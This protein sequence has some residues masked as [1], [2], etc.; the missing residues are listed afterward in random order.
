MKIT[1]HH[2]IPHNNKPN[3]KIKSKKPLPISQDTLFKPG[4]P[5][6]KNRNYSI[7]TEAELSN[8]FRTLG[9]GIL[10]GISEV[11]RKQ[12]IFEKAK[13]AALA[14]PNF[15]QTIKTWGFNPQLPLDKT[16]LFK[17]A[18]IH[19]KEHGS[20][21]Q[22]S[23]QIQEYG[24]DPKNP[25]DKQYLENFLKEAA[26]YDGRGTFELIDNWGLGRDKELFFEAAI[27]AAANSPDGVLKRIMD[28]HLFDP[29]IPEDKKR[30]HQLALE[31][32]K[33]RDGEFSCY[34]PDF[35][36][37]FS[38]P[39]E[40]EYLDKLL[41]IS[42]KHDGWGTCTYIDHY[43]LDPEK[44]K[45]LLFEVAMTAATHDPA[46]V[47][48]A[49]VDGFPFDPSDAEDK[50]RL[51]Q[52]ALQLSLTTSGAGQ[53]SRYIQHYG[54]DA[55]NPEDNRLLKT[56]A[57]QTWKD[58]GLSEFVEN[59]DN[60][61]FNW[62]QEKELLSD[63]IKHAAKY[64][65]TWH[66]PIMFNEI[67]NHCLD[68]DA[69][70]FTKQQKALFSTLFLRAPL[71]F[72]SNRQTLSLP[73]S[74]KNILETLQAQDT[75]KLLKL[76][77]GSM[78]LTREFQNKKQDESFP[79]LSSF[80]ILLLLS[81]NPEVLQKNLD[82]LTLISLLR[83]IREPKLRHKIVCTLQNTLTTSISKKVL[84]HQQLPFMLFQA[85]FPGH[86]KEW[87][88]IADL[89]AYLK[90]GKLSRTLM[91]VL[92]GFNENQGSLTE[93]QSLQLLKKALSG[94]GFKEHLNYLC[95]LRILLEYGVEYW[96]N[97][98][99]I[100]S[101][102]EKTLLGLFLKNNPYFTKKI[103]LEKKL[104]HTFYAS[105]DPVAI[106]HFAGLIAQLPE[107][108]QSR[109]KETLRVFVEAILDH[110]FHIERMKTE[111]N[112]H[113]Q[114]LKTNHA[115]LYQNW[116]KGT[117]KEI[118]IAAKTCI[119][120]N[121]DNPYD[122]LLSG[123]E[124]PTCMNIHAPLFNQVGLLGDLLN[125]QRLIT[126]KEKSDNQEAMPII[127]RAKIRL[128]FDENMH[129]ILFLEPIYLA[130][131]NPDMSTA[132]IQFARTCAEELDL[133]IVSC[134][135]SST[136]KPFGSVQSLGGR[137]DEYFDDY[138]GIVEANTPHTISNTFIDAAR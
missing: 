100:H 138:K 80:L 66:I 103:D 4:K 60:Y 93:I 42:A 47:A 85:I 90:D 125:G 88:S 129:P 67:V 78:E 13:L 76:S 24:F 46:G 35:G 21:S 111:Q 77:K 108:S 44:H 1:R 9:Q 83:D 99:F 133:S 130:T 94:S 63:L 22:I 120:S 81:D 55:S 7:E 34:L 2:S 73:D 28:H 119:L 137:A 43:R 37:D 64:S 58:E 59:I 91:H 10:D 98:D 124:T 6:P 30:L 82:D 57:L 33:Q 8:L 19:F 3:S 70:D 114:Y 15:P 32:A 20:K 87:Q 56:I 134:I 106:L 29:A 18:C 117:V 107:P 84:P 79:L 72:L 89:K 97:T 26:Q 136:A 135:Q 128:L 27:I 113:L 109:A 71:A 123:T 75:P 41:M 62:S 36:F 61:G 23:L 104:S 126:L 48:Q 50:F 121:T 132:I 86:D 127:G 17:L 51:Q 45:D 52:L 25:E 95:S 39:E 31:F 12:Q 116:Q 68:P 112:P 65:Y 69:P 53:L 102:F 40:M 105:R 5:H 38:N 16:F 54:F 110:S 115:T 92:L 14:D 122:L 131:L 49:I 74:I 11:E 96:K 118:K 101:S